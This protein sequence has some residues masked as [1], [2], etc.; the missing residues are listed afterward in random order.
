MFVFLKSTLSM[1]RV[2]YAITFV[3]VQ[4]DG[5]Y[6]TGQLKTCIFTGNIGNLLK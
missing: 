6:M 1:E 5:A 2:S 3:F 4:V